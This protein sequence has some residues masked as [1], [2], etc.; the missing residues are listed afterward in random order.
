MILALV[1]HSVAVSAQPSDLSGPESSEAQLPAFD[2]AGEIEFQKTLK[3]LI[4]ERKKK[5]ETLNVLQDARMTP[6]RL[7][8]EN[9]SARRK[10]QDDRL[11]YSTLSLITLASTLTGT[12]LAWSEPGQ[13]WILASAV[14]LVAGLFIGFGGGVVV[15]AWFTPDLLDPIDQTSLESE[16]LGVS[17]AFFKLQPSDFHTY[18]F[19]LRSKLEML[20][21]LRAKWLKQYS[22]LAGSKE[23]SIYEVARGH[24]AKWEGLNSINS[25]ESALLAHFEETAEK[26]LAEGRRFYANESQIREGCLRE[27]K[28][29]VSAP[30]RTGE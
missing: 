10:N 28:Q 29:L 2:S 20:D 13:A 21:Q 6:Y 8:A 15:S 1:F 5:L 3:A 23:F 9:F 12:Y 11:F 14:G 25:T 22:D 26:R 7:E 4:A 17:T 16:L 18:A 19:L 30:I 24:W 27:V